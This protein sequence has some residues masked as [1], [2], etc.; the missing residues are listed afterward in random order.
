MRQ[1]DEFTQ[2]AASIGGPSGHFEALDV[3]L[4]PSGYFEH[5][6]R[7]DSSG[8]VVRWLSHIAI[9]RFPESPGAEETIHIDCD[10]DRAP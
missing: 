9:T 2:A 3:W 6:F 7:R 10:F 5:V 8:T 4:C 1:Q